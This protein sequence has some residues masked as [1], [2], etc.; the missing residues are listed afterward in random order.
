MSLLYI[1]VVVFA[2]VP[3]LAGAGTL[4][5]GQPGHASFERRAS[6]QGA[7][8]LLPTLGN[9]GIGAGA[10]GTGRQ[11]QLG[12]QSFSGTSEPPFLQ[13]P[14]VPWRASFSGA[15]FELNKPLIQQPS[16]AENMKDTTMHVTRGGLHRYETD[17]ASPHICDLGDQADEKECLGKT[18][19]GRSCMWTR[20]ETQD[21]LKRIQA[22]NSY[23]L[24]CRLDDQAIPCWNVGAWVGDKRV[25]HCEMSCEHQQ[26]IQQP[27]YVCSDTSG[28]ISQSQCL[29]RGA[30]TGSRCMFIAFENE[31][32]ESQSSC[33]PCEV[34]GTGGWGCPTTGG[35]GPLSG[36]T[37]KSC[38]SQC[39]VLCTG[40]PACPPTVV[41]PPPPP[42]PSPGAV[43]V[44][45]KEDEMVSAPAPW[46]VPTVN[47]Y[48]IIQAARDAAVKAGMPV[49]STSP[50]PKVFWPVVYYQAPADLQYTTG[51]PPVL[52]PEAPLP[53]PSMAAKLP[54]PPELNPFRRLRQNLDVA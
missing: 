25:T 6:F 28:F 45:A 5:H 27:E 47:P 31:K 44:S 4:R 41:P 53:P 49:A 23:C 18:K 24:P 15:P 16:P 26:T 33:G 48:T 40:P 54:D 35:P 50:P 39:D 14:L 1:A 37:V 29:S 11:G 51:P 12:Q 8:M 17:T 36:T 34:Q 19:E 20:V 38:L 22:S 9:D 21:P 10:D 52:E 42:P 46:V 2:F 32:G 3:S 30:A 13:Q 7:D 43:K